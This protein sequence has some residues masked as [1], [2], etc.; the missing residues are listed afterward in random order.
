M[1]TFHS[2]VA[3]HSPDVFQKKLQR[4]LGVQA[5][6][7]ACLCA[8]LAGI[9]QAQSVNLDGNAVPSTKPAQI[10]V[11]SG[12]RYE[13]FVENLPMAIDVIDQK[14][15]ERLGISDIRDLAKNL[16]NVEVKRA[17]A[18][19]TVTGVGNSTGR[20][21]NA[22]FTIRG[23]DGNR[24]LMLV[25]G[26]RLPRSYIN[27]SNAF[28]R[29]S[30]AMN[31][32][33]QVEIVRGPAS[34]LY[35]SDGLAGLVNFMTLEPQDFLQEKNAAS[36]DFGGKL[37][38]NWSGDDHSRSLGAS[39]AGCIN[40]QW[41]WLLSASAS[42]AKGL[43][44]MGTNDVPNIDRTT[45]NP[46][47]DKTQSVLAKL[48]Y[49]PNASQ[50]H[51]LSVEHVDKTSDFELLSSRAK[52]PMTTA[53]AVKGETVHKDATRDRLTLIDRYTLNN[54][55]IDHVQSNLSYQDSSAQDDGV[56]HRNTLAD[57]VRKVSYAEQAWQFSL[58]VDKLFK[59]SSNFAQRL[60]YG[61]DYSRI[62]VSNFF[63]GL[64]P[65]NADFTPR[66]YFPDTRDSSRAVF[67]QDEIF[68]GAWIITPGV[69]YDHFDLNVKTQDGF[70]PPAKTPAKSL[71][72]SAVVP[73]LGVLYKMNSDWNAYANLAGGFRAPN[74]QQINGVFDSAT[75]PAVLLAN[76]DLKPEK[77]QNIEIG[78]RALF[79]KFNLDVA[80]FSGRYKDLIYDKKPLGG[81]G[82]AG[83][84][85]IFQTVNV[86]KAK[87]DGFEI[88]GQIQ[89]TE[90]AGGKL[91]SPFAYGKTRGT[92][93]VAH[94]PLS[95]INP[96]KLYAGLRYTNDSWDWQLNARHQA[97]KEEADLSSPYLPKPAVPPRV[98]QFLV[99]GVTT[100]DMQVQWTMQKNWRINLGVDNITNKKY[101]NWSDV[102]GLAAT[103]VVVDA[104]T[105][106]G[107][108]YHASLVVGF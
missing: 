61:F 64:D 84:P 53:S 106:P 51:S 15:I 107:R 50:K 57:R 38:A 28:G 68:A 52:L 100:M 104:Y 27:G 35:G 12:T 85:A 60:G 30:I 41:T 90:I 91:S 101:W 83:D 22:G 5:V 29:D 56:T 16:A 23:Q 82:I 65:G 44:N 39:L 63:D 76:P 89:W 75:V 34:V 31:L 43:E 96:S 80:V 67:L 13:Q 11:I 8:S 6:S 86:D 59:S 58:L 55:W 78:V 79:E 77:S 70:A 26:M 37:F 3:P 36:K 69:R 32:I 81:K 4:K 88:R 105:Q 102:Q 17:P 2:S 73:K 92:D 95:A 24:V 97:G 18:R 49:Q 48:V 14:E 99:P 108:Y 45:P 98:R 72:G 74:A 42:K 7:A 94:T 71:S 10:V 62:D 93:E 19:F 40:P 87:I 33:R 47:D 21:G 66:K 1:M 54:D 9:A 25:D 103:S 46:Q 20:D